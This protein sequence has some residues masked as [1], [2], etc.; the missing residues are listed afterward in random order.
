METIV[1][2]NAWPSSICLLCLL[3]IVCCV[4]DHWCNLVFCCKELHNKDLQTLK[5][6]HAEQTQVAENV[7]QNLVRSLASVLFNMYDPY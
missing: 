2:A 4:V 3:V 7:I 5:K 6:S 1:V